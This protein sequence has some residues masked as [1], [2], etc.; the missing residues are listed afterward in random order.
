MFLLAD[1]SS[2]VCY[3]HWQS[4]GPFAVDPGTDLGHPAG[5]GGVTSSY[6]STAAVLNGFVGTAHG[7]V[8]RSTVRTKSFE[9][10]HWEAVT[11]HMPCSSVS[12]LAGSILDTAVVAVGCGLDSGAGGRDGEPMGVMI[13]L[14]RG[15]T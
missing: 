2:P 9:G 15:N 7:G 6:E 4:V 8:W 5:M 13:T 1:S 10:A 14:D 12:A 3:S 11:D